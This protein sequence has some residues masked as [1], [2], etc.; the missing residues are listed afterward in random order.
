MTTT[1]STINNPLETLKA[2]VAAAKEQVSEQAITALADNKVFVE[3]LAKQ[4]LKDE[5]T[6]ALKNLASQVATLTEP[7]SRLF[8]YGESVDLVI[9]LA[10]GWLYAK[11]EV[12]PLVEA[13]V[14]ALPKYA[15]DI[16]V[17]AGKLPYYS[18]TLNI[19]MDGEQMDVSKFS[20]LVHALAT[21]LDVYLDTPQLNGE[22]VKS[23]YAKATLT[24]EF[25]ALEASNT[26]ALTQQA[27][28]L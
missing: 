20:S 9:Q 16:M 21:E 10:S 22:H 14:P 6:T 27:L 3:T 5:G 8:G 7:K 17:S 15:E 1:N 2:K 11:A 26:Q 13:V 28:D 25:A 24:A 4:E 23:L 18:K 12:K 19:V